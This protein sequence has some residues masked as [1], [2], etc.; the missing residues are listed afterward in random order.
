MLVDLLPGLCV[1][2]LLCATLQ[3]SSL[4]RRW[5]NFNA[6]HCRKLI[7]FCMGMVA[8]SFPWLFKSPIS[9]DILCAVSV[10]MLS[11]LK[12]MPDSCAWKT[13]LCGTKRKTYGEICFPI[14]VTILFSLTENNRLLYF[15]PLLILTTADALSAL[16]GISYGRKQYHTADG[17]KTT[18]GSLVF[19]LVAFLAAHI[20]LL[21]LGDISRGQTLLVSLIVGL[22]AM[23]F[24]GIAWRGVDNL[25]I[26][27]GAYFAL[28]THLNCDTN[29]LICRLLALLAI[30]GASLFA[31]RF[32]TLNGSAILGVALYL[33]FALI[34]GGIA[35]MAVPLI[36]FA[37]Y[38]RMLPRR[39]RSM[40][41][42]HSIYPVLA[43]ASSGLLWLLCAGALS[44]ERFIIPYTL[45]FAINEAIVAIAHMPLKHLSKDRLRPILIAVFKSWAL[46]FIPL[47]AIIGFEHITLVEFLM[48][49]V[50]I[51]GPTL[52][53][54]ASRKPREDLFVCRSIDNTR[55][56][57]EQTVIVTAGSSI[58]L[59]PFLGLVH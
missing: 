8:L 12:V 48:M 35:W 41:S 47:F 5:I 21:L 50:L 1:V 2:L 15:I 38:S 53:F 40:R 27:I 54:Y 3:L 55:R 45:S 30:L 31:K 59:I 44:P 20:P 11:L 57:I 46:T 37:S 6:E 29:T 51:L 34:L 56:W 49:P 36:V 4:S 32:T 19:L 9:V 58:G 43:I 23:L 26:P 39:F 33:Y 28:C 10:S 52:I 24:E 7:H 25:L 17:C 14:A 16:I 18:E 22:V 42:R 13:A